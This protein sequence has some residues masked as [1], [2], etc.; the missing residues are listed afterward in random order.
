MLCIPFGSIE[1]EVYCIAKEE[2][3]IVL[4]VDRS[5]FGAGTKVGTEWGVKAYI[6]A[7]FARS[8]RYCDVLTH[9]IRESGGGWR[10]FATAD[11]F[12]RHLDD[13][14]SFGD[15]V[16]VLIGSAAHEAM[17]RHMSL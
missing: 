1:P 10:P 3:Q 11:D 9:G 17:L 6:H 2:R 14:V 8:S 13:I 15:A 16:R 7:C 12:S 4:P 5:N